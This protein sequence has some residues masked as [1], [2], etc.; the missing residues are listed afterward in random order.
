MPWD[1]LQNFFA[2]SGIFMVPLAV[3]SFI[4]V[5]IIVQRALALRWTLTMPETLAEA[6]ADPAEDID[7]I[8]RQ[9]QRDRS[10]LGRVV[11]AA[12]SPQHNSREEATEAV[13]TTARE[14]LVRLQ[15]G[16]SALEV[17]ITIAPLLGLLGTVS[18]LVTVFSGIGAN[19]GQSPVSAT[20]I[21]RGIAEALNTTIAGLS[22]AVPAIIAHS[23]FNKKIERMSVRMEVL[24]Q[25]LIH[26]TFR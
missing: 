12:L 22:I 9:A 10:P 20:Q 8:A 14:E 1:R 24:L 2:Q 5:A 7:H 26:R 13:E 19:D 17:I 23:F 11:R 15:T 25:N 21:A 18:G 6:L 3:C 16:L 4:A